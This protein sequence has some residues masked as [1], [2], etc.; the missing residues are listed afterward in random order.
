MLEIFIKKMTIGETK[1]LQNRKRT[2]ARLSFELIFSVFQQ[3]TGILTL[4]QPRNFAHVELPRHL[5][6]R[7]SC[8]FASKNSYLI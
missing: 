4:I 1:S 8:S 7:V 6:Q 3:S 5:M 2:N